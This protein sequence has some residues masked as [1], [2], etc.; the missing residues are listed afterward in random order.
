MQEE[1]PEAER[2]SACQHGAKLSFSGLT[3]NWDNAQ[4]TWEG[5]Q[6]YWVL[7]ALCKCQQN[8]FGMGSKG[9]GTA[10]PHW[11]V[12]ELWML[13]QLYVK[14]LEAWKQMAVLICFAGAQVIEDSDK[15]TMWKENWWEY[16]GIAY[17]NK[18]PPLEKFLGTH[19]LLKTRTIC[20]KE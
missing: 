19:A 17:C 11:L 5:A 9:G 15:T 4:S 3:L 1:G 13:L 20:K 10:T 7:W 6:F 18:L 2:H 12:G 14:G 8:A 16:M